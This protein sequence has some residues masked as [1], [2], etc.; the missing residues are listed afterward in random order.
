I[1]A[2]SCIARLRDRRQSTHSHDRH[3]SAPTVGPQID[4]LERA[5]AG[6]VAIRDPSRSLPCQASWGRPRPTDSGDETTMTLQEAGGADQAPTQPAE[7]AFLGL[8]PE[9]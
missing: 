8:T 2:S 1:A 9:T 7:W 6:G 4:H 3:G 5:R